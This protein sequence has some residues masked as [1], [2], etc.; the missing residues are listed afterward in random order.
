MEKN[1]NL[2]QHHYLISPHAIG[3]F[4]NPLTNDFVFCPRLKTEIIILSLYFSEPLQLLQKIEIGKTMQQLENSAHLN[5]RQRQ[6][7][8][9]HHQKQQQKQRKSYAPGRN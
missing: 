2:Q 7:Q 3:Q 6:Q 4:I 5:A 8:Q 9:Q 1:H